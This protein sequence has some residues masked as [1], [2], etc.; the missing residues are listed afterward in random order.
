MAAYAKLKAAR[1]SEVCGLYTPEPEAAALLSLDDTP[2]DFLDR[3]IAQGRLA[4]AARFLAFALPRREAVWWACLCAREVLPVGAK[5]EVMAALEAAEAWV[6]KPLE[7]NRRAAMARAEATG[8]ASPCSWAAVGAFWSAGS[9]GPPDLPAVPPGPELTG[10][11]VS[12][13]I[14]MAAVQTEPEHAE[15]KYRRFLDYGL[16]LANGGTGRRKPA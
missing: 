16:D 6:Y 10:T 9:L 3:L 8:F 12:G 7:E 1:A 2:G 11:A 4:D 14:T 13:A 15:A 5:P